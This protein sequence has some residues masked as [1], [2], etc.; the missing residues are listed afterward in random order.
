MTIPYAE[1]EILPED[2]PDRLEN[3]DL[4]EKIVKKLRTALFTRLTDFDEMSDREMLREPGIGFRE[5]KAVREARA[6][7]VLPDVE[8]PRD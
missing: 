5:I 8:E 1:L 3:T 6:R 7:L 4:P 2:H